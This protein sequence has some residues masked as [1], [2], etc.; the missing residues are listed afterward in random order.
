VGWRVCGL[1]ADWEASFSRGSVLQVKAGGHGKVE[2][3]QGRGAGFETHP[4]LAPQAEKG[5]AG[6]S[7]RST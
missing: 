4:R 3:S 6:N 5:G 1:C 2:R 7:G